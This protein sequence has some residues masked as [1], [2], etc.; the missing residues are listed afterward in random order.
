MSWKSLAATVVLATGLLG[1]LPSSF[2]AAPATAPTAPIAP[3]A[4]PLANLDFE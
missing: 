1:P 3:T 4:A 2:A